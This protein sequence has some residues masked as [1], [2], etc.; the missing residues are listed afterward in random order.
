[1][2]YVYNPNLLYSYGLDP[3]NVESEYNKMIK[4][5]D[6]NLTKMTSEQFEITKKSKL[7]FW[8][9]KYKLR[10][11][12]EAEYF[13]FLKKGNQPDEFFNLKENFLR[14]YINSIQPYSDYTFKDLYTNIYEK[15]TVKNI[16]C[17]IEFKSARVEQM[18]NLNPKFILRNHLAQL[19]ISRA[20]VNDFKEIDKMLEILT[21][22]FSNHLEFEKEK[23]FSTSV[24]KAFSVCVSCS[25]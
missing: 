11:R 17:L 23:L 2:I 14:K 20:E 21:D 18:N 10:L 16:K 13:D 8:L 9:N 24:E 25:S 12:K 22:P 3:E 19:V 5:N 7:T 6:R 4:Y 1:M 15:F